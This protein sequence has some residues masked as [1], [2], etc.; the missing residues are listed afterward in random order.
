MKI[1]EDDPPRGHGTAEE[2]I[3]EDEALK[4]GMEDESSDFTEKGSELYAKV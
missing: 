2:G 3:A 1:S 4:Q